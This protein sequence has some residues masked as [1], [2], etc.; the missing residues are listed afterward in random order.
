MFSFCGG[1]LLKGWGEGGGGVGVFA[2]CSLLIRKSFASMLPFV[3]KKKKKRKEEGKEKEK[4]T[5]ILHTLFFF[6]AALCT[7]YPHRTSQKKYAG[8]GFGMWTAES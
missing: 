7:N 8:E 6:L 2:N 1:G 3:K 4:K 5:R